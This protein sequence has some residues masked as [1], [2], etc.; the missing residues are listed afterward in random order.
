MFIG[1]SFLRPETIDHTPARLF[2]HKE[3]L[4]AAGEDK[5]Y[6]LANVTSKCAILWFKD[7]ATCKLYN[8]FHC[9]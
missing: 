8:R 3:L 6:S 4:L 1:P 7:Y 2:Y 5:K 9:I